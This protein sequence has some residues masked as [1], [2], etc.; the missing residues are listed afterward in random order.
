MSGGRDAWAS[1]S[2]YE[3]FMGRWSRRLAPRFVSW[4]H[5][6]R[7]VHWLDVGCGTG[8]LTDAVC[9]CADPA[10]VVGCDPAKPF[11]DYAVEHARDARA[12]FVVAGAGSLPARADGYGCAA[13]LLALNFFPDP[14][15]A[16]RE[17][18][19]L[20]APGGTVCACVWDYGGEMQCLRRFW[21]AVGAGDSTARALD[22]GQRFP[23]C[24]PDKLAALFVS[25]GLVDVSSEAIRIDTVFSGF[26]D[27]WTPLLGGT[28]PAATYVA[29]LDAQR[30]TELSRR[31]EESLPRET[32]GRIA[33]TARAWAVRGTVRSV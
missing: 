18:T 24:R 9:R 4:L 29:S 16:T 10:S 28:G 27:Y 32:D 33:L 17:M 6:P 2:R 20:V 8:A 25:C 31:L 22:E 21:D 26:D 3:E 12:T 7:G 13:S 23:L 30:R 15:A 19:S 14:E 11:I 1:A 5:L